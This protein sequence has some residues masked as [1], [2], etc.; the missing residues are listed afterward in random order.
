MYLHAGSDAVE[1]AKIE[2]GLWFKEG[3]TK[4]DSHSESWV[5]EKV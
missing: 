3:I 1:T 5:Y 2:I 4:W